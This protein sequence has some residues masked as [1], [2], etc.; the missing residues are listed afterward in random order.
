MV[1]AFYTKNGTDWKYAALLSSVQGF[2]NMFGGVLL[3]VIGSSIKHWHLQLTAS[4]SIMVLFGSLMAL[5][6][7]D[8]KGMMIAFIFLS[9]S[10]YGY[11]IYLSIA[12]SQM[13][14]EHKDL[15]LSGGISGVSRFAAGSS[16]IPTSLHC[17]LFVKT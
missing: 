6:T 16:K 14:V 8:N 15:G 3:A 4:V 10:G 5:G 17:F 1:V 13:G 9:N 7:P 12:I 2:G 11:S